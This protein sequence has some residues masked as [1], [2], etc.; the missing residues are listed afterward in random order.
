MVAL[1]YRWDILPE[2]PLKVLH[3]C[4]H[5]TSLCAEDTNDYLA[6]AVA[7]FTKKKNLLGNPQ[8]QPDGVLDLLT[9]SPKH[10]VLVLLACALT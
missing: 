8:C 7:E 2:I 3:N 10:F 9:H 5:V 1:V 6:L 4:A